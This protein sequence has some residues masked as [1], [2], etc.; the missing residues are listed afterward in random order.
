MYLSGQLGSDPATRRLVSN[1]VGNQTQQALH[2]IRVLL[3]AAGSDITKL[4]QCRI[5]LTDISDF[6][7]M[8]QIYASFFSSSRDYP[9]RTTIAVKA[10][11]ADGKVEIECTAYTEGTHRSEA[12]IN[13]YGLLI[14]PVNCF[15]LGL[16]FHIVAL[17]FTF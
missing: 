12:P 15:V 16:S 3:N 5:F 8:N 10:L 17:L 4:L 14:I 1:D 9:T 6:E 7:I 13:G 11:P 2:N